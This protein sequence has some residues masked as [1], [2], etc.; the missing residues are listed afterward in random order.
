MFEF[1]YMIIQIDFVIQ[2]H[3]NM[4]FTFMNIHYI[5]EIFKKTLRDH[6]PKTSCGK[7]YF[8]SQFQ[9]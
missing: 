2:S 1:T 9:I 5:H 3:Q 4:K 8:K 7:E 6:L